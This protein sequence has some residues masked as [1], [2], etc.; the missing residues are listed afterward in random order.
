MTEQYGP[1]IPVNGRPD[2]LRDNDTILAVAGIGGGT[3]F[4]KPAEAPWHAIAAIR[5]PIT[6]PASICQQRALDHPDE[7]PLTPHHADG[8]VPVDYDAGTVLFRNDEV[9]VLAGWNNRENWQE[10]GAAT[11]ICYRRKATT[12]G[13]IPTCAPERFE[14]VT[15]DETRAGR[16]YEALFCKGVPTDCCDYAVVSHARGKEVCRVWDEADARKIADMLGKIDT[17]VL[18][19][20][21]TRPAWENLW[22]TG[23]T[24]LWALN[25]GIIKPDPD[26]I[27]Q[28][29]AENA[30]LTGAE[31][32]RKF[33]EHCKN[34]SFPKQETLP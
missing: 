1:P 24:T 2:W 23:G 27:E 8:T 19:E 9:S 6:H 15:G 34:S 10:G 28:F 21:M 7:A 14:G 31:L 20:R 25:S 26:P 13:P 5:L 3:Y 29:V 18:V 22:N 33:N 32:L 16:K 17:H 30:G 11:I 4:E 12:A